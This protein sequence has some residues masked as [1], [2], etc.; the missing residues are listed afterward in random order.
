M[1]LA[2]LNR[3]GHRSLSGLLSRPSSSHVA[4]ASIAETEHD[5][6]QL[7]K[8]DLNDSIAEGCTG[9]SRKN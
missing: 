3:A 7:S 2:K 4:K 6:R 8:L 9:R 1:G 5:A